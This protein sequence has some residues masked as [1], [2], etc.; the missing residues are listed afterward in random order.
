[1]K[2][3]K[4]SYS[5]YGKMRDRMEEKRKIEEEKHKRKEDYPWLMSSR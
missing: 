2:K 5:P 3:S 1:M 4:Y